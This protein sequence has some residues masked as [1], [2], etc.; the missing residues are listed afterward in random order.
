MVQ[1]EVS[2]IL[3]STERRHLFLARLAKFSFKQKLGKPSDFPAVFAYLRMICRDLIQ[4]S[5]NE[6]PAKA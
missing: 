1:Q 3:L 4:N 5:E 6:R 2:F